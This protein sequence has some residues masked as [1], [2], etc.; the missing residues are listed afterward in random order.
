MLFA[1][2]LAGLA[3]AQLDRGTFTG[4]VTD[5]SGAAIPGAKITVTNAGTGGNYLTETR[6]DGQFTMPNLPIGVYDLSF[7]LQGF[8]RHVQRGVQ[9]SVAEVR[10]VDVVLEIGS[11]SE[12][13]EVTAALP[14]LQT[15]SSDVATNLQSGA[16][17]D[18]PLAIGGGGRTM[19]DLVYK[20]VPG[21]YG[22]TWNQYIVGSQR[23][24]KESLLEGA[25]TITEKTGHFGESS[26]SMEAVQEFKVQTSAISAEFGRSQGAVLNYVLKS[27]ANDIHGSAYGMIRNEALNA[28]TFANNARGLKRDRDRKYTYAFSFG[29]PVFIPEVYNGK[30][31]TF[32][33]SAYERYNLNS[34]LYGS[35]NMSLPPAEFYDGNLSRLL[36]SGV[37]GND[38]L[39]NPVLAGAVY[40][41]NTF[42]QLQNG[43]WVGQM[44]PNNQI[45][46]SRFSQVSRTVNS[47]MKKY[48]LPTVVGPDGKTPLQNNAYKP[49]DNIYQRDQ[50]QFSL[51]LDQN[52]GDNHKL[53]GSYVLNQRPR[54][55]RGD[56]V[57]NTTLDDGGP[58]STQQQ[59]LLRSQFVRIAY[60]WTLS[61]SVLNHL[62]VYFN[63]FLND[64]PNT[65]V[66]IDGAAE[67]G[68]KNLSSKGYPWIR[69]DN[70]PYINFTPPG[71]GAYWFTAAQ[72]WGLVDTVNF[73]AG[74]HFMKAGVDLRRNLNNYRG[75]QNYQFY[76]NPR[77]TAIPNE[78]FSGNNTG[79]GFASYLLGI[80]HNG[81]MTLH[82]PFGYLFDYAGFFLQDD[83]KVSNKLSLQLGVRWD[84]MSPLREKHDM[85]SNWSLGVT[86]PISG[87]PGAYEFLGDC[88]Q[89]NGE[90]H[91]GSKDYNNFAPR[92]GFAWQALPKTTVRG[93][94]AIF[95]QGVGEHISELGG[96]SQVGFAPSW[97]LSADPIQPWL[98]RF[99]WDDGFPVDS[100][101]PAVPDVSWGNRNRPGMFDPNHFHMPYTQRWNLNIQREITP[102]L[103]LD[104][105]YLGVKATGMYAGQLNNLNQL[106]TS[107]LQEFGRNL[108]NPVQS[109]ADAT[110][111]GI[112]YPYPGYQGTVA[113]AL[114]QYPQVRGSDTIAV[115]GT[116]L[117]FSTTHSFQA[118]LDKRF[119]QGLNA[120]ISYT[121]QK[122]LTN[123]AAAKDRQDDISRPLDTYN[124][125]LEKS[126]ADYDV[127]HM[128]KAYAAYELPIGKGK[129]LW[130]N[131]GKVANAVVGGWSIAAI[132]NYI[133]GAPLDFTGASSPLGWN[134]AVQRINVL[135]GE[136]KIAGFSKANFDYSNNSSPGNTYLNKAVYTDVVGQTL[137]TSA[138]YYSQ[139]RGFGIISEDF[140][141]QK[142]HRIAEKYR[143]QMRAEFL[144]GFNRHYL[145]NPNTNIKNPLFGQVTSVSGNRSIQIGGRLDF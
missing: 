27:G 78:Q 1:L 44:F 59:Q 113:G 143:F 60:D 47:I 54:L 66:D 124:L 6:A 86:D 112:R 75:G 65:H 136:M 109:E 96:S 2:L 9:L 24:T 17:N 37:V 79:H 35:P 5:R 34:L 45:P 52:I 128:F 3:P 119:S 133:S 63:R 18:L 40:D 89:C 139:A 145:G 39:G 107:V 68:I 42:R 114:R 55:Q 118:V 20:I 21:T 122:T 41:P 12:S 91:F 110:K 129:P 81:S 25:S 26:M 76:F 88:P 48:Y 98:G 101:Q 134:G 105:G 123:V 36:Q 94:Y 4:A 85:I 125:K 53:S 23:W 135:P 120:Y 7:E 82:F 58:L 108:T 95:F 121:W 73:S 130:G 43:R 31:K 72:T 69:W 80:V 61:P 115:S 131:A 22:D 74:R 62:M 46:T 103:V 8:N 132:L 111:N 127:P 141:L 49:L 33:Y 13:I 142:N 51:K 50:W 138:P 32:F 83:F 93:S 16:V 137:G 10:R 126:L 116:P 144:N 70:G 87:L 67:Y 90:H 97:A 102:N 71:H 140:G 106:P 15:D 84:Y 14:R 104:V 92:I 38:A 64:M 28:N 77:G 100:L 99:R 57:W 30:N 29:G 11:V 19:E 56:G 117:G